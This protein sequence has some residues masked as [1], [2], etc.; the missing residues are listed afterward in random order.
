MICYEEEDCQFETPFQAGCATGPQDCVPTRTKETFRLEVTDRLPE[1]HSYLVWLEKRLKHC[2]RLF[3]DAPVGR[4]MKEKMQEIKEVMEGKRHEKDDRQE[5]HKIRNCQCE[6]FRMLKG[7]FIEQ[8]RL[9]PDELD[10]CLLREVE[11][12]RCPEHDYDDY[13]GEIRACYCRL[14]ELMLRYQYDCVLSDLVFGCAQPEKACCVVLGTVEIIDGRLCRVCNTPRR[15]VWSF[16]N[17]LPV[18][19]STILTG[20]Q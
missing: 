4:L 18:A 2:F 12:L 8:I 10:C 7:Y 20:V 1:E 5:R 6:L 14:F 9:C 19:I 3:R 15:Y 13:E 11:C 17:L 16:A